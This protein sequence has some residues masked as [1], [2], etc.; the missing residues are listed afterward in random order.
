MP[1]YSPTP[2][3]RAIFPLQL[4]CLSRLPYW[5]PRWLGVL[6]ETPAYD[7]VSP[8]GYSGPLTDILEVTRATAL[9]RDFLNALGEELRAQRVVSL[10]VRFH[11]L[12]GNALYFPADVLDAGRRS[13]TIFID[14]TTPWYKGLK[15]ACRYEVRKSERRGVVVESADDP[16]DWGTFGDIYRATMRRRGAREWYI[17]S[18]AFFRETRRRLGPSATLLVARHQGKPIGGS[19]FLEGFGR[20]N[21]HLS[22]SIPEGS[23]LG[24]SNRLVVE[25]AR[26]CQSHG[27]T[28]LHLGGGVAPEDGLWRFKSSFSPHRAVWDKASIVL[29]EK[30]YE[31]LVEGRR[32]YLLDQGL[33]DDEGAS[34]MFPAYRQGLGSS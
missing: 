1:R 9:M 8:Y 25:G 5:S 7:A 12:S 15:S 13:E 4:R 20:G 24:V 28:T 23:G 27:S 11:P 31:T 14:L 26:L 21:Y 34:G 17:F 29:D 30:A 10:F 32:R 33:P 19:L 16:D 3:A 18:H 2:G 22:G 6:A